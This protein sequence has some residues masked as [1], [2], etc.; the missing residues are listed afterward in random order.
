[1]ITISPISLENSVKNISNKYTIPEKAD[2]IKLGAL[3][4]MW[5]QAL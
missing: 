1:M 3:C 2:K 4:A 5:Q